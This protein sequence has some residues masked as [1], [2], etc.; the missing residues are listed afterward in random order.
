MVNILQNGPGRTEAIIFAAGFVLMAFLNLNFDERFANAFYMISVAGAFLLL[1]DKKITIPLLNNTNLTTVFLI[2]IG[3]WLGYILIAKFLI[4]YIADISNIT[5]FQSVLTLQAQRVPILQGNPE[6]SA[7]LQTFMVP[8]VENTFFFRGLLE[9]SVDFVKGS[10]NKIGLSMGSSIFSLANIL[11][12]F[13]VAVA[14]MMFHLTVKQANGNAALVNTFL[15]GFMIAM[16][17]LAFKQSFSG[18]GIHILNNGIVSYQQLMAG[19]GL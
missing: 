5:N 3:G 9:P 15:F 2:S 19:V 12:S 1:L 6:T 17:N 11:G 18:I 14:F 16:V 8:I 7:L 10:L 4:P 13:I